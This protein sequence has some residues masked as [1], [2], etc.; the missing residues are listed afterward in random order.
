M[1]RRAVAAG[2]LVVG[3]GLIVY[4]AVMMVADARTTGAP[5]SGGTEPVDG[6][7]VVVE[8]ADLGDIPT[9]ADVPAHVLIHNR[10]NSPVRFIGGPNGCQPGGCLRTTGICPMTIPS[11]SVGDV[12]LS[13]SVS[14]QGSF[15]LTVSVYL[16]ITG[17]AVE[18]TVYLTGRGVQPLDRQPASDN[19]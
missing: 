9:G 16:D 7:A 19:P 11:N 14:A 1:T 18:R 4:A 2:G 6:D 8:G 3:L 5:A 10:S 12:P 13:V 15:R 17:A